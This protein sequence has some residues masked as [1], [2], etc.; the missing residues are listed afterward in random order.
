[1]V[2]NQ[3][4]AAE[5]REVLQKNPQGL[6]ITGI[7][8]AV[9]INRNT[10]GRYLDSLLAS[11]QVEMRHFG[12]AK[13]YTL[14]HRVPLS[15]VLSISS[16]LILQLDSD[17][18]IIFANEPFVSFLGTTQKDLFGKN[19]QYSVLVPA[20]DDLF[21][22]FMKHVRD[23]FDGTEWSGEFSLQRQGI[24]FACRIAPTAFDNGQKGVSV[25][26]E[27][28]TGRKKGEEQV[29]KSEEL[30]RS[31]AE[32]SQDLIFVINA[33]DRVEYVNSYAAAA[34]QKTYKEIIGSDRSSIFP[35]D[36]NRRQEDFL[37]RVFSTG[38]PSRSEN[39]MSFHGTT[40]WFDHF[41]V[42]LKNSD[43]SVRAVLGVSRD[44]TDRKLAEKAL[45][46]SE[47]KYRSILDTMQDAYFRADLNGHITMANPSAAGIFGYN[48]V[49]EM[50][51]IP[52]I[53]LYS[54]PEHRQEILAMIKGQGG[55]KDFTS[56]GLRKDGTTFWVSMN[57]QY[58]YD[59]LGT[60][61]GT[62]G[63]I[64]DI[65][66]RKLTETALRESEERFRRIFED[67]PLGMAIL[68]KDYRFVV[69][70][71]LLC[72]MLGYTAEELLAM[73]FVDITDPVHVDQD[74]AEVKKLYTG[75]I[76]VY[77][78]EKRYIKK[79]GSIFWG[80]L[81][82]SPLKDK[83]GHIVSTIALVEDIAAQKHSGK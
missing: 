82:V 48:S 41:L 51:G 81:T 53:S 65:T 77:R 67:G 36:I 50:I 25:I 18:R 63:F 39:A 70:N 20:L 52:A 12:M 72:E 71:P 24:I 60:I 78:T 23:G 58:T 5:I 3:K 75:E 14:S 27:D 62:E 11:G 79:D 56:E 83:D 43:G 21:E 37:R 47:E 40:R 64:R 66:E 38:E 6:S 49:D 4:I 73:T 8:D 7:V 42:P 61:T 29:R 80:S 31:L 76:A 1:M 33:Q 15:A 45:R 57:V 44:I 68:N 17:L 74:L 19:I 59:T 34:L 69:A 54:S 35:Q 22:P 2:L 32:T 10:A 16:D 28:I 55:I 13:I 46:E 30:Y 9:K 26:F